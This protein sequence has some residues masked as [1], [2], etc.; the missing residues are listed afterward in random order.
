MGYTAQQAGMALSVGALVVVCMLP[1]IGILISNADARV[2]VAVGFSVLSLSLFHMVHSLS[3]GIDFHTAMMMRVYQSFGLAF[4]FVPIN[5][6]VYVGV[7]Q[8]KSNAVS[9]MVNLSRNLGGDIGIAFVTTLI[10][11]RTVFHRERLLSH[12]EQTRPEV[13]DRLTQLTVGSDEARLGGLARGAASGGL[14]LPYSDESG[15]NAGVHRRAVFHRHRVRADGAG[16][17]SDE[18][19][20]ESGEAF[21]GALN[22]AGAGATATAEGCLGSGVRSAEG[23]AAP[24]LALELVAHRRPLRRQRRVQRLPRG[25]APLG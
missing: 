9:G 2:L 22:H 21:D 16:G 15:R 1:F 17:L 10:A 23:P 18:A 20:G 3:T 13:N 5:T 24:A 6:L 14:A 4:L 25:G 7:P 19:A 8:E 11:R 12:L